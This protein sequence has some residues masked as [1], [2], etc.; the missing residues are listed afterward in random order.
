MQ[1]QSACICK[2]QSLCVKTCSSEGS[3]TD[4]VACR[5]CT[6]QHT[7]LT[8]L[9]MCMCMCICIICHSCCNSTTRLVNVTILVKGNS[10]VRVVSPSPVRPVGQAKVGDWLRQWGDPRPVL[11]PNQAWGCRGH[12]SIHVWRL[13]QN[14]HVISA[15]LNCQRRPCRFTRQHAIA[16]HHD[17]ACSQM[18]AGRPCTSSRGSAK[19][20][21]TTAGS[22]HSRKLALKCMAM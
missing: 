14:T 3:S 6:S 8:Q 1:R 13:Q 4:A 18:P 7:L 12:I 9:C 5:V 15:S 17:G 16:T 20:M 22:I 11:P 10:I 2:Q 21:L 19:M